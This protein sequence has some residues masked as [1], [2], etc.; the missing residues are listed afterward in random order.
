MRARPLAWARDPV[1]GTSA[2]RTQDGVPFG[3]FFSKKLCFSTP[4]GQRTRVAQ[5][6]ASSGSIAGATWA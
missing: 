2:V 1:V 3:M 4:L 5:R 6:S